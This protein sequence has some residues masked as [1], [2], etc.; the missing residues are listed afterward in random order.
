MGISLTYLRSVIKWETS[1][2]YSGPVTPKQK[3]A[4]RIIGN[5]GPRGIHF[6]DLLAAS[7]YQPLKLIAARKLIQEKDGIITLSPA[8]LDLYG[9]KISQPYYKEAIDLLEIIA[10][11][12]LVED[13]F[14]VMHRT[15]TC[16][17][18]LDAETVEALLAL[19]SKLGRHP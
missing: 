16:N 15:V 12:C 4:V 7:S 19:L 8:G 13:E 3:H 18:K 6:E 1:D 14:N 10:E 2:W 5:A 11:H 17:P 9:R